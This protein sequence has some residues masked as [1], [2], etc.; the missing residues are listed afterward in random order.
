MVR[1]DSNKVLINAVNGLAKS[2]KRLEQ[3]TFFLLMITAFLLVFTIVSV[4]NT[5]NTPQ[6]ACKFLIY[7]VTAIGLVVFIFLIYKFI[8]TESK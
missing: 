6:E 4:F 7:L 2:S 3:T 1:S 8:S 5:I